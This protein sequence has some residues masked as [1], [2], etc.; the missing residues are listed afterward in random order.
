MAGQLATLV[1]HDAR[2][3][4]RYGIYYAYGFVLIFYLAI[5]IWAG[6]WLPK[7]AVAVVIFTDP[8]A[9][10]FFF[11]GALMMLERGEG[12]RLALAVTPVSAGGYLFAKTATLTLL[13]MSAVT[14]L[15]FFLHRQANWPLLMLAVALTSVQYVGIGVPIALRFRTVTGY[16]IGSAGFLTPVIA[17]GFLA[18]IDPT[19]WWLLA[20]PAASQLKLML[21]AVGSVEAS[22]AAVAGMLAVCLAAAVGGALLAA[23]AL[24]QELG[25]K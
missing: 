10:G 5:L 22:A 21:V 6:P 13:A 11:L 9:L 25:V 4:K 7:W 16:L 12:T 3:Q 2:L 15:W 14:I 24:R 8:S 18:L 19:P 20:I 23:T 17:P 1:A